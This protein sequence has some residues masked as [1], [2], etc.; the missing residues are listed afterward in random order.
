MTRCALTAAACVWLAAAA[1]AFAQDSRPFPADALRGELVVTLPPEVLLN[2]QPSRL[3]PGARILDQR[4]LLQLS[5]GIVGQRLL[6]N[7]TLDSAGQPLTVWILTPAEAARQP[8]PRT[9][10]EAQSWLFD[11]AA[12][13]WVKP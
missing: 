5:G 11:P 13:A 2:G 12:Q 7:Y 3:A 4:N 6:V 8:W 9:R 10:A 1:P